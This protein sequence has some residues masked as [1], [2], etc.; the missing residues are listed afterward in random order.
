[1]AIALPATDA[2]AVA[3]VTAIRSGDAKSLTRLLEQ[4][5]ELATAQIIDD[6]GG[7]GRTLLHV[8]TDWPGYYP[9]GPETVALLLAAGADPDANTGGDRPETPLHWAASSD[10]LDVAEALIDGG[11]RI[12]IP[13]GSIGTPLENAVGYGCWHVA[14]LLY[15]QGARADKLWVAAGLGLLP[16]VCEH[17]EQSPPPERGEID[18]AFWQ[19]CHGGQL[20]VAAYLLE[21]GADIDAAPDHHTARPVEIAGSPDTRRGL[22]VDWLKRRATSS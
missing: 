7:I 12:D 20:R 8:V 19:A 16:L 6:R 2:L 15:A 3:S 1:M 18:H 14:R 13:G 9:N 21:H 22:L 4:R 10:D 11:A 17:V 5:P